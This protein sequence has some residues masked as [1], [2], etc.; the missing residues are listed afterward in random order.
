MTISYRE[1]VE[2]RRRVDGSIAGLD[3]I[4]AVMPRLVEPTTVV[5]PAVV[6]PAANIS[7]PCAVLAW[8]LPFIEPRKPGRHRRSR[9][10][11][12]RRGIW[13]RHPITAPGGIAQ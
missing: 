2:A 10:A 1:L 13:L 6:D 4:T 11:V 7:W 8:L 5:I 12:R 9:G 3:P